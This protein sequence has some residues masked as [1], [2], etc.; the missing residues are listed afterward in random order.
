VTELVSDTSIITVNKTSVNTDLLP[1]NTWMPV[2]SGLFFPDIRKIPFDTKIRVYLC[3]KNT[4]DIY[5]RQAFAG[6]R[7]GNPSIYWL[8]DGLFD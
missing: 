4:T 2:S 6:I 1:T 7:A 5:V 8:T 3:N